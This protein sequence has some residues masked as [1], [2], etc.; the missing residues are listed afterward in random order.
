MSRRLALAFLVLAAGACERPIRVSLDQPAGQ[1]KPADYLDTLQRW[2]RHGHVL[3]DFDEAL[4][5]D[6]T[7]RSLEFRN[8]FA[9]KYLALYRI[10]PA[11]Q[12]RVRNQILTDGGDSFEFHVESSTHR[13]ELNDFTSAKS[14]WRV[15]LVDD[16]G[17]EVATKDISLIKDR[18]EFDFEFYPYA[19]VFTRGWR[20]RFPRKLTDGTQLV[21][22]D[23]KSLTLR[24]AGPQGSVD[25]VW[26]LQTP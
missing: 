23:T 21:G 4:Y 6:A 9:A 13:F 22:P 1:G 17:R 3:D 25:L 15:V 16:R 11:E 18:R 24:I 19:N 10:G 2:T 26:Q 14:V 5:I 8:A 7:L 20:V 12:G